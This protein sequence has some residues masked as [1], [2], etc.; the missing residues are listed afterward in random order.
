M[1]RCGALERIPDFCCYIFS[2]FSR[3]FQILVLPHFTVIVHSCVNQFIIFN[4][5]KAEYGLQKVSDV[6]TKGGSHQSRSQLAL[7]SSGSW[8]IKAV[9]IMTVHFLSS[10]WPRIRGDERR[11]FHYQHSRRCCRPRDSGHQRRLAV[12]L[13]LFS[14]DHTLLYTF[15]HLLDGNSLSF[16]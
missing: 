10:F 7:G 6:G 11:L 9:L 12:L 4:C 13:P 8:L 15:P 14:F 3:V 16:L 5:R 2:H 1:G